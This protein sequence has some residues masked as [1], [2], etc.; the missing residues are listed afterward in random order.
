[1]HPA[2][3]ALARLHDASN[4]N[5]AYSS[6]HNFYQVP[7]FN[8]PQFYQQSNFNEYQFGGEPP[9]SLWQGHVPNIPQ[10]PQRSHVYG[11][12][13]PSK[14]SQF[15]A[16]PIGL[17]GSILRTAQAAGG[18]NS[19]SANVCGL[20]HHEPCGGRRFTYFPHELKREFCLFKMKWMSETRSEPWKR[21]Q[22]S[23]FKSKIQD[24]KG[25]KSLPRTSRNWW[26]ERHRYLTEQEMAMSDH[27]SPAAAATAEGARAGSDCC[28][29]EVAV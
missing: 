20:A 3:S 25:A 14:E 24:F 18:E 23:F 5:T 13:F 4:N 21:A 17:S 28:S 7:N 2:N 11:T 16:T 8:H 9:R 22:L 6:F 27:A 15:P 12:L 26:S 29:I 1:M 19:S 10:S